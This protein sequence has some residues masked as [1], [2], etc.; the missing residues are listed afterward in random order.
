MKGVQQL[1]E[2]KSL[3]LREKPLF[4]MEDIYSGDGKCPLKI[5]PTEIL[6]QI[7]IPK[8]KQATGWAYKK[9]SLRGGVEFAGVSVATVIKLGDEEKICDH[10]R[11]IVGAIAASPLRASKAETLLLGNEISDSLFEEVA[12]VGA[13]EIKVVPHHGYSTLYLK[14][15][16]RV[17]IHRALETA[18]KRVRP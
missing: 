14:E 8:Q 17:Q 5:G 11:I 2:S 15:I 1:R 10:A 18:Y 3:I 16:L 7:M 12:K 4:P 6:S 9:F 13:D